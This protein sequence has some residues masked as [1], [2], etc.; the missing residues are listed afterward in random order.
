MDLNQVSVPFTDYDRS[1]RFYVTLGLKLIVDSPKTYARFET[2]SGTTFSISAADAGAPPGGAVV[3]FEVDDVDA[4]V[5]E[6]SGKGLVFDSG[7][8]DQRWLWREARLRD[9]AGNSLCI[10]HAGKN[11]RHPPWR[12]SPEPP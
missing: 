6:L 9:P 3:Y 10:Y 8:I 7:P 2:A 4:T 1:V 5:R 12:V 11:R